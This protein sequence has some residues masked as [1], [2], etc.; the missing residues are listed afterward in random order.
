[1]GGALPHTPSIGKR[2][3]A[4]SSKRVA[5]PVARR[6]RRASPS[7]CERQPTR[8]TSLFPIHYP[9]ISCQADRDFRRLDI[10]P[11]HQDP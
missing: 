8:H 3:D 11:E 6:L 9:S 4:A 5:R 2:R 1:M 10:F 7:G